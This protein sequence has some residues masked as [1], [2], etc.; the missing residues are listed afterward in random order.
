MKNLTFILSTIII[1]FCSCNDKSSKITTD[2]QKES[3]SIP[4][5]NL[6][7]IPSLLVTPEARAN[8]IVNHFWDNVNFSDTNF[9]QYPEVL[10]QA[11][12][13]YCDILNHVP[14]QVAQ[15]SLFQT[16]T[17][18]NQEKKVFHHV[19]EL[20]DKYLYHPNSPMRNEEF[21]IRVLEA[22]IASPLLNETE[23]IKPNARLELAQKNRKGTKA[24]DFIYTLKSGNK[25]TLYQT[26]APFLLLFI[27]NPGCEACREYIASIESSFIINDFIDKKQI[28]VLSFYPDEDIHEWN[29]H[30]NEYSPRWINGYDEKQMVQNRNIYDLRA[31]PTLYLLDKNKTVLLKDAPIDSIEQYLISLK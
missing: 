15:E 11:W 29:T 13:D 5:F 14:L 22:M 28:K 20:A 1:I 16:I 12:A 18:I 9:I 7:E 2:T 25:K 17:S 6:P 3:N 26:E 8:Y 31:I 24:N 30:Y 10:E 23:K 27:N 4:L 19:T 21:Y